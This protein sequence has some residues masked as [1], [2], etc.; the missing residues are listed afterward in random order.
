MN[1]AVLI[2]AFN[3]PESVKQVFESVRKAKPPRLYISVDAPRP[4]KGMEE[5]LLCDQVKAVFDGVDWE[6]QVF[7]LYHELNQGCKLGPVNA[8]NWFFQHEEFGII[9]EDDI[10]PLDSFYNYCEELLIKYKDDNRIGLI[11]GSNLTSNM[12]EA[13]ESYV[14]SYYTHIWGWATWRRAWETYDIKMVNWARYRKTNF[15]DSKTDGTSFF[16]KFW[17]QFFDH[18]Y[19][20]DVDAWDYQWLYSCWNNNLLTIVPRHSLIRNI[21]FGSDATHTKNVPQYI[22]TMI[23]KNM[24]FPL[25]APEVIARNIEFDSYVS[26][27]VFKIGLLS[28]IKG[29]VKVLLR[30]LNLAREHL[31][32]TH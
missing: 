11:G 25:I 16:G 6:C 7:K 2:I 32:V 29:Y 19:G 31:L 27:F 30:F 10:V 3:R 13:K 18:A 20:Y 15:V 14:F 21:G 9:L 1:S 4:N 26:R 24:E 17:T 22:N 8:I 12:Y 5:T 28:I 23:V